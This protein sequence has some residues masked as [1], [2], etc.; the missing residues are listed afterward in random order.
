MSSNKSQTVKDNLQHI[1]EVAER[2]QRAAA[3]LHGIISVAKALD[4]V[5]PDLQDFVAERER[6]GEYGADAAAIIELAK[7]NLKIATMMRTWIEFAMDM[8]GGR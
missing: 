8:E 4:E 3:A 2:Q 7:T 5:I 6:L 1:A